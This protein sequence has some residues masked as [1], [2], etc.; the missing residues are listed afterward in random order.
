MASL[1]YLLGVLPTLE[2]NEQTPGKRC[3]SCQDKEGNLFVLP[4]RLSVAE[5]LTDDHIP[6]LPDFVQKK[7]ASIEPLE[8]S[9][10]CLQMLRQGYLYVLEHRNTGKKWRVFTASPEGCLIEHK[11]VENVSNTPPA[12]SCNIVIDG[13]DASYISFKEKEDIIK[14]YFI[15]SPNKISSKLLANY[16]DKDLCLLDGMTPDEIANGTKSL[17]PDDFSPNILEFSITEKL[18]IE[19]N[20]L[21][22]I[23]KGGT[24]IGEGYQLEQ[25]QKKIENIYLNCTLFYDKSILKN[26]YRYLSIYKKLKKFH[27]VAIVVND[28][29]GITQCLN[30]RRHQ[31]IEQQ[32]KPWMESKDS[33][34]ISNEYRLI[35]LRQ[36][37]G[38][39]NTFHSRRVKRLLRDNQ[40]WKEISSWGNDKITIP[41]IRDLSNTT[42]DRV[43]KD[44][45]EQIIK[46]ETEE[47]SSTEFQKKYWS[48]LSQAKIDQFEREFEKRS[49][50]AEKLAEKRSNDYIKWL[51]SEQL[52]LALDLY[53]SNELLDGIQFSLQVNVCLYGASSSPA[54]RQIFDAWWDETKITR[55]N[56]CYR[57]YLFNIQNVIDDIN[58][59]IELQQS[60]VIDEK[61]Q[62]GD[63]L[64]SVDTAIDLLN[65][66]TNHIS[67]T[68]PIIDRLAARGFPIAIL[69]TALSD[70]IRH[71]LQV[72][73]TG[74][75]Q[76]L[77]NRLGNIIL[78]RIDTK[79]R[80]LYGLRIN[81]TGRSFTARTNNGTG[82]INRYARQNFQNADLV[83]TRISMIIFCFSAYDTIRKIARGDYKTFR[84]KVE[85][86]ASAMM[87][88]AALLQI[89]IST[90]QYCIGNMS[91]TK[92]SIVTYNAFGRLFL[93][94]AGLS[95][96]AGGMSAVSDFMDMHKQF[97]KNNTV[98]GLAYFARGTAI[99]CLSITQFLAIL[100]TLRPW[101]DKIVKRSIERT[102]LIY[103]VEFGLFL[104]N[105]AVRAAISVCIA[106]I[107][108]Y[109]T[110]ITFAI[111]IVII[112]MDDN[113]LQKWFDRCCF[114][115]NIDH[116][117][118]ENLTE[119]L[120][121]FH[122]AV[123]AVL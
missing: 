88:V 91:D 19:Q 93:W 39:K 100:G 49:E 111:S 59:Y 76:Q 2:N 121:E 43:F 85:L 4:T 30:N 13:A 66:F 71:F 16:E 14:I 7:V 24:K 54:I 67:Q 21:N 55:A 61:N 64:A 27:G 79:A 41:S 107:L 84:E 118:F 20:S 123:Q 47:V 48:R 65:R 105:F 81:I 28:A 46:N 12:Y 99:L 110:L 119:E 42:R 77:H 96:V 51:K 50:D 106:A 31:A 122:Q 44:A 36:L 87:T 35:I 97:S 29:I 60:V 52:L 10:Y 90:I 32:M 73:V 69:S 68:G 116:D 63:D 23:P 40:K 92:T 11:D 94:G 114:S 115:N 37:N 26:Y 117:K 58:Q 8:H 22:N 25:E 18:V 33:E 120:T 53:D 38:L 89:A 45:E 86:I 112:V 72:T 34:G 104:G 70:L 3:P 6:V 83:N 75:E 98:I 102:I 9:R 1:D 108:F 5:S 62:N 109:G 74:F 101:L 78:S 57:A 15:F 80:E 17:L 56:L 103:L 82:Q 113:A 95:A